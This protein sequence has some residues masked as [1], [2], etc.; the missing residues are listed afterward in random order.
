M[1]WAVFAMMTSAVV[2][3]LAR[4]LSER[5]EGFGAHRIPMSPSIAAFWPRRMTTSAADW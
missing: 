4:S 2:L 5:C 1:L 3:A